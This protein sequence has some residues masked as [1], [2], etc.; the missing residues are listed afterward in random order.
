M[1]TH[2]VMQII[3]RSTVEATKLLL[4]NGCKFIL[5]KRFYQDPVKEY[6]GIQRP[7]GEETTT[8]VWRNLV[9]MTI[10]LES[11]EIYVTTLEVRK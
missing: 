4:E 10:K 5:T 7:L 9:T 8:L 2:H 6:F 3:V 11:R 1:Q